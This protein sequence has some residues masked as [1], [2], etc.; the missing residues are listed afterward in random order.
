M[1]AA[2]GA[3]PEYMLLFRAAA[4][5]EVLAALVVFDEDDVEEDVELGTLLL[6]CFDEDCRDADDEL[7]LDEDNEDDEVL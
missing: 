6:G 7:W 5:L 2:D 3:A 1:R 4:L